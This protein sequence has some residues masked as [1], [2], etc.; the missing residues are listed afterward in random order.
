MPADSVLHQLMPMAHSIHVKWSHE[1]SSRTPHRM[2]TKIT[3]ISAHN[4]S[5]WYVC[6]RMHKHTTV[7]SSLLSQLKHQLIQQVI[8]FQTSVCKRGRHE[9]DQLERRTLPLRQRRIRGKGSMQNTVSQ[10][11]LVASDSGILNGSPQSANWWWWPHVSWLV[12][13]FRNRNKIT[14]N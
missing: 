12:W 14:I 5:I 1:F 2:S 11:G 8:A 7:S 10:H 3:C 9:H 4:E 6:S 13:I